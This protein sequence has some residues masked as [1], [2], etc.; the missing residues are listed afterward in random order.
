MNSAR[1]LFVL[2][3]AVAVLILTATAALAD[4]ASG[5]GGGSGGSDGGTDVDWSGA[6]ERWRP[7]TG[8]N[9]AGWWLTDSGQWIQVP[10]VNDQVMQ[11]ITEIVT[12]QSM[13]D[14]S[15]SEHPV[16]RACFTY[17]VGN[18]CNEDNLEII[19]DGDGDGGSDGDGDGNTPTRCAEVR[20][21]ETI[22]D[23]NGDE[24]TRWV[25]TGYEWPSN[26]GPQN[27]VS[28]P[29][30]WRQTDPPHGNSGQEYWGTYTTHYECN[31]AGNIVLRDP[32]PYTH[33][34]TCLFEDCVRPTYLAAEGVIRGYINSNPPDVVR[35][36]EFDAVVHIP[37]LLQDQNY[38]M[39]NWQ[40][41]SHGEAPVTVHIHVMPEQTTFEPGDGSPTITC[42]GGGETLDLT[43]ESSS[44]QHI[45]RQPSSDVGYTMAAT[46]HWVTECNINTGG[47][48]T[49][50][51]LPA[52]CGPGLQPGPVQT[53]SIRVLELHSVNR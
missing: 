41:E 28:Q 30:W 42:P 4:P 5:G 45:Y 32:N 1:T 44:C 46:R 34:V 26:S 21:Q 29:G 3:S 33:N 20:E 15:Y 43:A 38:P 31:S 17:G 37:T 22:T 14:D 40:T 6:T 12:S 9:G 10:P 47:A 35:N 16:V 24:T 52:F 25:V 27:P 23:E 11:F 8:G 7:D 13:S 39:L 50:W 2:T 19:D 51:P 36:P 18:W 53:D 49:V 48:S